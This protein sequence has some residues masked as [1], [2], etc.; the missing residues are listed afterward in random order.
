M[1]DLNSMDMDS[2]IFQ[3]R[4]SNIDKTL[5]R[6]E[7]GLGRDRHS[8]VDL[9][10]ASRQFESLLLNF[11]FREMRATVPESSLFPPSMAQALYTGMMDEQIAKEMAQNGGIGISRI[12][13]NQLNGQK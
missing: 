9:E 13:F 4:A 3:L 11:M 10:N 7:S 1:A 12:I 6:T 2:T 5:S 8:D